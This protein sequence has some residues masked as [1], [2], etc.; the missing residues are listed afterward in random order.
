MPWDRIPVAFCSQLVLTHQQ[1]ALLI[2]QITQLE[3]ELHFSPLVA[4]LLYLFQWR[5]LPRAVTFFMD[6]STESVVIVLLKVLGQ[7]CHG[8]KKA[9]PGTPLVPHESLSLGKV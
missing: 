1:T 4:Y 8:A 6:K 5:A 3:V 2:F 7:R 9:R